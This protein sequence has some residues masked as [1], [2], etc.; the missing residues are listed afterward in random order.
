VYSHYGIDW[1]P[2]GHISQRLIGYFVLT[3]FVKKYYSTF[4]LSITN[5]LK[6]LYKSSVIVKIT[7][8]ILAISA[9][10]WISETNKIFY[11]KQLGIMEY[12]FF[13]P[14][15]L[16]KETYIRNKSIGNF[17]VELSSFKKFINSKFVL[18]IPPQK[19]DWPYEGN[20]P[21][22][23]GII[24]PD[25]VVRSTSEINEKQLPRYLL[26]SCGYKFNNT[27]KC[28]PSEADLTSKQVFVIDNKGKIVTV[29]GSFEQI[30]NSDS[31]MIVSLN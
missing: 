9:L 13:N 21:L 15:K 30:K 20:M 22:I 17:Y 1:G 7:V 29:V 27:V 3:E 26:A 24:Y 16:S 8:I 18:I 11:D 28:F 25:E 31:I 2:L 12:V 19:S 4:V 23:R 10:L 6:S 5:W 14:N